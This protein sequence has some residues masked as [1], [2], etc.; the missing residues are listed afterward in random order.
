MSSNDLMKAIAT[1]DHPASGCIRIWNDETGKP[2]EIEYHLD[3]INY[4]DAEKKLTVELSNKEKVVAYGVADIRINRN[5]FTVKSAQKV[6]WFQADIEIL[7]YTH[8]GKNIIGRSAI[9]FKHFNTQ[10]GANA[11]EVYAKK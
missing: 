11:L 4:D 2:G 10:T 1:G 5:T 9:P 7:S 3:A 6:S 8:N